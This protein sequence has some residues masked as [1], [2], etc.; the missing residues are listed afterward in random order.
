ME[1]SFN[2]LFFGC[3]NNDNCK[4][5]VLNHD[6]NRYRDIV[7]DKMTKEVESGRFTMAICAG[8]NAYPLKT[9][10]TVLKD[11]LQTTIKRKKVFEETITT[12]F[13]KLGRITQHVNV[14]SV[15]GNHNVNSYNTFRKQRNA[16]NRNNIFLAQFGE[17]QS[18]NINII[19]VD[20]AMLAESLQYNSDS[21]LQHHF[22]QRDIVEEI[23]K[24]FSNN[25]WNVIVAH[26]PLM[27]LKKKG[28]LLLPHASDIM[29]AL[30]KLSQQNP[31]IVWLCADVHNFHVMNVHYQGF[32]LPM[33]VCGCGGAEPDAFVWKNSNTTYKQQK[34]S[35]IA[36][37]IAHVDP[38]GYCEIQV[39]SLD[40]IRITYKQV[41]REYS[42]SGSECSE[43]T[44]SVLHDE[45]QKK[46]YA[47]SSRKQTQPCASYQPSNV[48]MQNK[49][50]CNSKM[51]SLLMSS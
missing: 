15:V 38:F 5:N 9:Q 21:W 14:Y 47:V 8:D 46:V 19:F 36:D 40:S 42:K 50:N 29:E 30:K 18:A 13:S 28:S 20:T 11:G 12:G 27:L 24:R 51:T 49:K 26:H 31:R 41:I 23:T 6:Y 37:H 16:A 3:W 44:I 4:P 10:E 33:V 45:S 22:Y 2:F 35:F 1:G 43:E 39:E 32:Q 48:L 17:F 25:K 7:L 34:D